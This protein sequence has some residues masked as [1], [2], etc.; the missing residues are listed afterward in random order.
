MLALDGH[1]EVEHVAFLAVVL[2]LDARVKGDL[3]VGEVAQEEVYV[4]VLLL[5]QRP[6]HLAPLRAAEL[7]GLLDG[8]PRRL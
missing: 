2:V 7:L 5:A 3:N 1:G 4:D 6:E 8:R